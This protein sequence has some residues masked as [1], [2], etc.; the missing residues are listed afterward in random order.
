MT[1]A[2]E[3]S[4]VEFTEFGAIYRP[5]NGH[6]IEYKKVG[7]IFYHKDTPDAVV[8]ALEHARSTRQRIR[9]YYGDTQTGRDWHEEH[10]VEGTIGNS[11]GP[12]R[13]P[14]LIRNRRSTG[15]PALLDHCIVK[16]K[17]TGSGRILYQ[18][19]NYSAGTFT[20]REISRDDDLRAK[21]YTHGVQ[22]D[23]Q[24]HGNFK[25]LAA[26]QRYVRRMIG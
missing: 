14:L 7:G 2:S 23:G 4:S 22:V 20:V 3:K 19:P 25:S 5:G 15:G 24:N 16:I 1:A 8:R 18:H 11:M 17:A 21:G 10:D 26:A 9:I 12:L 6:V 13:V